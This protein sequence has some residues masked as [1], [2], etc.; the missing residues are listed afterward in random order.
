MELQIDSIA[1]GGDGVA[2][3]EGKVWFIPFTIPGEKVRVEILSE[4]KKIN[5]GFE[6]IT[7]ARYTGRSTLEMSSL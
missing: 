3:H 2:R 4:Q 1:F 6:V 7:I 5:G